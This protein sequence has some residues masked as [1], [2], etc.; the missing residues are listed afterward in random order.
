MRILQLEL[1]GFR[2]FPKNQLFDM[3]ADAVVII[4]ENGRGKTSIF[5]GILWA[6]TGRIP[7]LG[8]DA[9]SIV[10]MYSDSGEA[11]VSLMIRTNDD[12]PLTIVRRFDGE[13]QY[14]QV[15]VNG[16]VLRA[17]AASSRLL[18]LL[19][20][21][22]S[23]FESEGELASIFTRSTYL[24]QDLVREFIEKD[25]D[26]DRFRT[27]SELV[28]T[29]TLTDLTVQ[30]DR[31]RTAWNRVT[32][33]RQEESRV[34]EERAHGLQGRLGQLS[35]VTEQE[36][37]AAEEGWARWWERAGMLG[38]GNRRSSSHRSAEAASSLDGAV[39]ELA[40]YRRQNERR[41]DFVA[42]LL[43]DI[44]DHASNRPSA[45]AVSQAD[46][47][48][49]QR[50]VNEASAALADAEERAAR[51]RE[52]LTRQREATEE[53]RA[54]AQLALRHL[55]E[56]CPVCSQT[57]D[58]PATRRR[59]K[60]L[61]NVDRDDDELSSV[62]EVYL[63]ATALEE[64]ERALTAIEERRRA[65]DQHEREYS[66]WLAER[67]RRLGEVDVSS[68][69]DRR[70]TEQELE[71]ADAALAKVADDLASHEKAGEE[72][73]LRLARS[74]E[75]ARRSELETEL[76]AIQKERATLEY[77]LRS[78]NETGDL[79]TQILEALR[80]SGSDA[81]TSQVEKLV[82]LLQ[83][84][85][86]RID[87]HPAFRAITFLTRISRGR[88]RLLAELNDELGE[89]STEAPEQVFSS[90]QVNAL[91]VAI[92]LT[93]N[94]GVPTP[95]SVAMLDDPL[96]SLDD[97][98]LLGLVDLLRRTKDR[99]QLI[100]STHDLRFG[101][102]LE[103]K[104]RPILDGQRTRVITLGEWTRNGP[105]VTEHDVRRDPSPMR[106]AV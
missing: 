37:S 100:V 68:Q 25:S 83:R 80:E 10:S 95:L 32:N 86:T 55:A 48:E 53:L 4:G 82:P 35:D 73:A 51:G 2:G 70:E 23:T 91:A 69:L 101:T 76:E 43:R 13:Q 18:Q 22:G 3:D 94:L 11:R 64:S 14:L 36:L 54:L 21:A 19:W 26:Q 92:F 65:A 12:V 104:L 59:L 41:R 98:N 15:D 29:G 60:D 57:Y 61:V 74:A 9:R 28:G 87:P 8:D 72:L 16:E 85:Y 34:I 24:Q 49:A 56:R 96:Q 88:G 106:I 5:D 84:I 7:R 78:R 44:R 97:V 6:M 75:S 99:R 38:L 46:M 47:D 90:S 42:E 39:R 58:E 67:E 40:A 77:A 27:V 105:V 79:A 103:Q 93:L 45:E 30:L 71:N 31:A 50:L 1:R 66:A 63:R 33:S 20:P 102:L 52:A 62:D 17:S 81:V 89:V